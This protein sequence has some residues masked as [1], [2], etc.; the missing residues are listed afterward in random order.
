MTFS[1]FPGLAKTYTS[2]TTSN[3]G[4]LIT[5]SLDTEQISSIYMTNTNG[6]VVPH[7]LGIINGGALVTA[8]AVGAQ[9]LFAFRNPGTNGFQLVIDNQFLSDLNMRGFRLVRSTSSST[10]AL[11]PGTL[12]NPVD[13]QV[14]ANLGG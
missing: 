7:W 2:S 8:P 1:L 5:S 12:A 14:I 13:I 6:A 4:F 3:S 9:L 10:W 11:V